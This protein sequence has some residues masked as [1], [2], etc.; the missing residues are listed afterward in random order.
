MPITLM[1]WSGAAL[2]GLFVLVYVIHRVRI[3]CP[4]C[5]SSNVHCVALG[6]VHLFQCKDCSKTFAPKG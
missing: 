2:V 1:V 4:R 3:R 5:E 6:V